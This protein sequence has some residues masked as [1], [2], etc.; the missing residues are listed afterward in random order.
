[1][2]VYNVCFIGDKKIGKS[3]LIKLITDNIFIKE[4]NPTI[5]IN[6]SRYVIKK[7][8]NN[9]YYKIKFNL[10][11]ISGQER[12]KSLIKIYIQNSSIIIFCFNISIFESFE[13]IKNDFSNLNLNNKIIFLIGFKNDL[14]IDKTIDINIIKQFTKLNNINYLE[15]NLSQ[16][17][18]IEEF[19]FMLLLLIYENKPKQNLKI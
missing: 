13:R 5:G 19:L 7:I 11:E 1:M 14:I 16:K 6:I 12:F 9:K 18:N 3:T 2:E 8:L 4:Y 10:I 17:K 15:L